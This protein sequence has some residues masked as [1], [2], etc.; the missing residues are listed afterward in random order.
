MSGKAAYVLIVNVKSRCEDGGEYSDILGVF[1]SYK[2]IESI[3]EKSLESLFSCAHMWED[4][5]YKQTSKETEFSNWYNYHD[6][7]QYIWIAYGEMTGYV[8]DEDEKVIDTYTNDVTFT[9][10]VHQTN[11][12]Y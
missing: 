11:P 2:K 3:D 1:D 4:F 6:Q 5:S 7:S 12:I 8:R 10:T 9:L